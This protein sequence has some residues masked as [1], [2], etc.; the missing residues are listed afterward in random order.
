[1]DSAC[2]KFFRVRFFLRRRVDDY[3]PLA[4]CLQFAIK[5]ADR[6]G[7]SAKADPV[8]FRGG[9]GFLYREEL[10]LF[11]ADIGLGALGITRQPQTA[12]TH[13]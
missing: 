12:E 13:Q 2:P 6:V 3:Q 1:M 8:P 5:I 4:L 11:S 10:H 7:D 9:V